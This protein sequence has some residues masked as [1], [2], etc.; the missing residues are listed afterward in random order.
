[1]M[2]DKMEKENTSSQGTQKDMGQYILELLSECFL[3]DLS[4]GVESSK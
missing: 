4:F 3:L 1:M 2:K